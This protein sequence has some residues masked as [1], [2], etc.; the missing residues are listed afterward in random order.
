MVKVLLAKFYFNESIS[1]TRW[2]A[3]LIIVGGVFLLIKS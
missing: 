3:I 2:V 1:L